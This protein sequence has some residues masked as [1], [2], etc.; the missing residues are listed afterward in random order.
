MKKYSVLI[1]AAIIGSLITFGI[2]HY[3]G[4]TGK[5]VNVYQNDNPAQVVSTNF[6]NSAH[7]E[8]LDFTQAASIAMP[9]VVHIKSIQIATYTHRHLS[10]PFW[11]LFGDEF[12]YNQPRQRESASSGS[13]VI[14]SPDG[15]IVT[16]N[17]VIDNADKIEISLYDNR[18]FEAKLVGT[19]PSTDLALIKIDAENLT[20]INL[21]NSDEVKVG[22]FV[23]AVGN[24]F[25]LTSTVTAGIVSA[26]ARSIHILK[27]RS[28][29][30]SFIQ[31]D[32]AVNPG[33]SGGALVNLN[34]EL[35][36]I[37]SAI[38]SPTGAYAGYSFAIP[39]KIVEKVVKDLKKY[40]VVQRGY[41]GVDITAVDGELAKEL[42]LK[43][44][45]GVYV[46]KLQNESS[47]ADAGIKVGDVIVKVNQKPVKNPS[48]LQE[49]VS[50][51]SPGDKISVTV[52]RNGKEKQFD[53]ILKNLQGNT[54]ILEKNEIETISKLGASFDVI[55]NEILQQ[56]NIETAVQVKEL[57]NGKLQ[58]AGV[59]EGFIIYGVN[60][61]AV[62]NVEELISAIEQQK[63]GVLVE[64]IYPGYS[65]V[66]YYAFGL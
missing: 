2:M 21:A 44:N 59:K 47:A 41:M 56:Y 65:R 60:G 57:Y 63:G 9:A 35:V 66:F 6:G 51:Y 33:N 10:N 24:P 11:E 34:G 1:S 7:L 28:A 62:S 17:H 54:D 55:E 23:L 52:N 13:G 30:E 45:K 4:L 50:R 22:E 5:V 32:A 37:N 29:I 48:E 36:G 19:D 20:P 61:K 49:M 40:G 18:T 31:T 38:A 53:V 3:F 8:G 64:G 26:K 43:V 12:Y 58:Q 39:A 16:N 25:N 15:Y 27:G 14:L 42:D 46:H